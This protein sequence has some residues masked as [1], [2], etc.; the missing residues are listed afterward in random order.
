MTAK[1]ST[2]TFA[3]ATI[4]FLTPA[5][6][7]DLGG[8]KDPTS[9]DYTAPAQFS[10]SGL[11]IGG[12][13]G[14][15]NANHELSTERYNSDYC[16][17]NSGKGTGLPDGFDPTVNVWSNG[18]GGD[19]ASAVP[20]GGCVDAAGENWG[21]E[22]LVAASSKEVESIDGL[23][24]SG[25]T[26]GA[27]L[28]YDQQL[29]RFVVGV[30]GSYDLSSMDTTGSDGTDDFTLI[31]KGDEWSV[32]ARFGYLLHPRV[33][34]YVLAAYTQAD[35]TFHDGDDEKEITFDGVTVGGGLEYALTQNVFLGIEGT[36][37]FYG[38][39]K[40]SDSNDGEETPSLFGTS[41]HDEIGETKVLGT[42]KIK[43]NSDI[44]SSLGL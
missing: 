9:A 7:A 31:D 27:Q 19:D 29:G 22:V 32:G 44:G 3:L 12:R 30:F 42:L 11:Y 37:T 2:S 24:S 10:W 8:S 20:I 34:A 1:L 6:A 14:Y 4:F 35:W 5:L 17:D 36:H 25:I 39:E 23:N 33:L 13:F 43:L 16:Y 38:K 18:I 41:E 15:G 40:I 28:G 21:D 26:G